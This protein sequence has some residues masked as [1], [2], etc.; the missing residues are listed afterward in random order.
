VRL[1]V[2]VGVNIARPVLLDAS[3]F[4]LLETPLRQVDIASAKVTSKLSVFQAERSDQ[5]PDLGIVPG[6]SI[7]DNLDLPVVLGVT[8]CEVAVAG[9]FPVSL[10]DRSS[11]LV[12]VKVAAGLSVNEADDIAVADVSDLGV[13]CVVVRLLSVGVEEPV[14][15]GV[16]VVV[17]SNLLLG[18]AFGVCLNVGV[19]KST[20]VTHVL[21]CRTGAKGDFKRA[22]LANFSTP[23]VGLEEGRHLRIAGTAVLEDEEVNIEREHVDNQ[24]DHNQ[25][26]DPE[27]KVCGKIN[28]SKC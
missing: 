26:D 22:V 8:D 28:L 10:G 1:D 27:D 11:D 25:A 14:V 3:G 18:R 17:A 21:E 6:R 5:G 15:V 19:Q 23:K 13:L 7:I 4:N 24:R 12:R 16:L 20:S 2:P 9:H